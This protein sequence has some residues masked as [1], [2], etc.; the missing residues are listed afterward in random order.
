MEHNPPLRWGHSA[1]GPETNSAFIFS[2]TVILWA[3]CGIQGL[4][5]QQSPDFVVLQ[6]PAGN[7]NQAV[8]YQN[9]PELDF[10]DPHSTFCTDLQMLFYDR[11]WKSIFYCSSRHS[12][13]WDCSASLHMTSIPGFC[14]DWGLNPILL[15]VL[16]FKLYWKQMLPDQVEEL[17]G[18][19]S[20]IKCWLGMDEVFVIKRKQ[21]QTSCLES[22]EGKE[23]TAF[24]KSF[25]AASCQ[26]ENRNLTNLS[27]TSAQK[28]KDRLT[29]ALGKEEFSPK[30]LISNRGVSSLLF[31]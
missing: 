10:D 2:G 18:I 30:V 26:A 25:T 19:W 23:G 8:I 31:V 29:L 15:I 16:Q 20:S 1:V 21:K 14:L 28:P 5:H 12:L 24:Q 27:I 7:I 13:S 4:F 3:D 9:P 6:P 11:L 17:T 22:P